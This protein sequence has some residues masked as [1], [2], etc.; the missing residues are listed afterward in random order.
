M[1]TRRRIAPN[2]SG[3]CNRL[4]AVIVAFSNCPGMAGRSPSAPAAICAFCAWIAATTSAVESEYFVSL[5]GSSQI[6][7]AYWVP[8]VWISPTPGNRLI[9][10]FTVTLKRD[11]PPDRC[12]TCLP[13]LRNQA[14]HHEEIAHGL[15]YLHPLLLH[16]QR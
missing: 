5:S 16:F 4:C 7:I 1:L 13:S 8:K 2:C 10:S 3:V 12:R 14:D 9:G 11:S 6:R 15:I